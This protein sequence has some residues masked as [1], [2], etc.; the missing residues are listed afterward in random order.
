VLCASPPAAATQDS[1][2]VIRTWNAVAQSTVRVKNQSDAQAARLYAM[3]NVA[4]Y[5]AVNG[6]DSKTGFIDRKHALVPPSG[7][8]VNG[9]PVAAAAAAA[10][11]VLTGLFPDQAA[12]YNAQ[13]AA[14]LAPLSPPSKHFGACPL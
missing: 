10:H 14:D 8:P 1:G 2:D 4:I 12:I 11:G 13:L 3:V 5:D 7:A 6:I 9:H